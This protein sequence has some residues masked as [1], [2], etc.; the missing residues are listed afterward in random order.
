MN[1]LSLFIPGEPYG[2]KRHRSRVVR[3]KGR[4]PFAQQYDPKENTDRKAQAQLFMREA[5]GETR[6]LPFMGPVSLHVVADFSCPKSEYRKREPK[7]RRPHT[8]KPDADN[9]LKWVK[10]A[11]TGVLWG[12]DSQVCEV[13]I[14]KWIA[15]QGEAPGTQV[16]VKELP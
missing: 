15:A 1:E 3:P 8:K 16:N 5:I 10:D 7:P 4:K 11:G 9:V 14:E 12:D 13:R 2:L 6:E